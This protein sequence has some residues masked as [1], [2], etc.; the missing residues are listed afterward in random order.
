MRGAHELAL[1]GEI[2][3]RGGAAEGEGVLADGQRGADVLAGENLLEIVVGVLA[4]AAAFEDRGGEG[5][6][7]RHV[8]GLG[9][10]AG[11]DAGEQADLALFEIG[12]LEV[13]ADLVGEDELGD[14]E[15]LDFLAG[16]DGAGFAEVG[17]VEGLDGAGGRG[18]RP[19]LPRESSKSAARSFSAFSG[20]SL[21]VRIR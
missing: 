8:L 2:R 16:G 19:A 13:D 21:V 7:H 15:V 17:V 5:I 3:R 20:F 11:A 6:E 18:P 9:E 1:G 4:E 12:A 14:A 10:L